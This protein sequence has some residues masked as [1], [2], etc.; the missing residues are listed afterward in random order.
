MVPEVIVLARP[1]ALAGWINVIAMVRAEG[2]NV[3][4]N[5][6]VAILGARSWWMTAL[7][8][9]SPWIVGKEPESGDDRILG[10]LL[11][12]SQ[13]EASARAGRR[14]KVTSSSW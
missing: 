12:T 5:L 7:H 6:A 3:M 2:A 1:E 11:A 13:W 9:G 8:G 4:L 14:R 10:N